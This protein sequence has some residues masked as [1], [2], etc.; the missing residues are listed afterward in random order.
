[1]E[2]LSCVIKVWPQ[3]NEKH[4]VSL[5]HYGLCPLLSF[6]KS[7]ISKKIQLSVQIHLLVELCI[8]KQYI[9][10][11]LTFLSYVVLDIFEFFKQSN[12]IS[13]LLLFFI[14]RRHSSIS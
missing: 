6:F 8:L 3:N 11:F 7:L 14:F 13:S 2:P 12:F 10:T 4:T 5:S 1:M 9:H